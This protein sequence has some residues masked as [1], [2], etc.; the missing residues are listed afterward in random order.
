[1]RRIIKNKQTPLFLRGLT[2]VAIL[3]GFVFTSKAQSVIDEN[4]AWNGDSIYSIGIPFS[5]YYAQSFF[6]NEPY[7]TKIGVAIREQ[8]P[9]GQVLLSV[10]SA[11][12][13]GYPDLTNVLYEGSLINPNTTFTWY[14]EN[15]HIRVNVGQKYFL[16]IDG[17][18]NPGA[19]GKAQI[20]LS[21]EMTDTHES[22]I[23]SNNAGSSW[24]CGY[25]CGKYIAVY[26]EGA[27]APVPV[28][29][30]SVVAAFAA[31]IGTSFFVVRRKLVC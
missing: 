18:N 3:S 17:Y 23:F 13:S 5:N 12:S 1:M 2:L 19:S 30:W 6:A 9:E 27:M 26:V 8:V 16:L 31:L 4:T 28:L 25:Y 29:I 22:V 10:V 11:N 24:E 21:N 14:Y 15:M 20:G 7:I